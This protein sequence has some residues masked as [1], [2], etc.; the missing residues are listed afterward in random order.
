MLVKVC[1][2]CVLSAITALTSLPQADAQQPNTVA[3]IGFLTP[4]SRPE[5][6]DAFRQELHR[7]GYV[8]G[9]N[10]IVEFRS[11]QGNFE[12]LPALAAELV[13]L[14]VDVIV[15]AVSQASLA[16]KKATTSIPIVMVAVGDPLKSGLVTSLAHPGGNI[17]GTSSVSTEVV[18]KQLEVLRE[19]LPG[20][21]RVATL[22]NPGNPTFQQQLL[23][24]ARISAERLRIQLQLFEARTPQDLKTSIA[25][26]FR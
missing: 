12:R 18:G 25:L 9:K 21:T 16:A 15:A 20:A 23:A 24:E 3:R 8:E 11:A 7:L 19:L 26:L 6:E 5:S 13:N 4:I 10:I 1:L 2:I 22:W 17:T 14:K